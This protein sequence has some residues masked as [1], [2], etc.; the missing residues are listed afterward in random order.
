M[1]DKLGSADQEVARV[2]GRQH[3]VVTVGQLLEA[4]LARNAVS[5]RVEKGLLHREHRGVYR[6]GHRAPSVEAR[7][8][9]AVMACG[10]DA[11]LSGLAAAFV[12][13]LVKGSAPRPEVTALKSRRVRGVVTRR[14]RKL[15]YQDVSRYR[16]IPIT[17]LPRTV[18]DL[19]GDLTIDPLGRACHEAQVRHRL[20]APMVEKALARRPN[21]PGAEKL[22]RIFRGDAHVTLSK[23]ERAFLALL[24]SDG[25]PL[26]KTNRPAGGRYVDCR[27]PEYR[28]TV[29]LDSY[30]YHHT[31]HAWEQDRRRER[32]ARAR[33][34][35][36]R[37]YTYGDVTEDH[38]LTLAELRV[39]LVR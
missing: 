31:R 27:W 37:R 26:P 17:T 6:V 10:D 12:Y 18:V 24:R 11:V 32:E 15:A 21:A 23:L 34:D 5:R 35:E 38:R 29:E 14:V 33:G 16:G 7:Y 28:L 22:Q 9:A 8:M 2:A 25:L 13:G 3:G 30:R 1:R 19:A 20:T 4:G 36:F 39:L